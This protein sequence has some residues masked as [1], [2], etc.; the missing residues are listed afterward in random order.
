MA[1]T[2]QEIYDATVRG[3]SPEERLRLAALI[4]ND[5]TQQDVTKLEGF[6]DSWSEEDMRDLT[7]YS[8]QRANDA[9][10]E[11]EDA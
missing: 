11:E 8:L 6:S 3:L 10:P 5:L 7:R 9:Y 4:L 1:M 2:A